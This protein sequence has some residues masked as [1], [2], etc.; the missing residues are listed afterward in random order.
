MHENLINYFKAEVRKRGED[1][2]RKELGHISTGS[3]TQIQ[4]YVRST[5]ALKVSLTATSI[6]SD[7]ITA[8]CSC[9]LGKKGSACK[10]MWTILLA[11]AES[12]PDFLDIKKNFNI[13]VAV[14][15]EDRTSPLKIK[16][17]EFKKQQYERQKAWAKKIKADKKH[18]LEPQLPVAVTSALQFFSQNGFSIEDSEALKVALKTLA[19][20]FHPDKGGT[21]EEAT[22]LNA[23]YATLSKHFGK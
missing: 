17:N 10:H 20:I 15:A 14:E 3:D 7:V 4:A 11:T 1:D 16:Q 22:I 19:R 13:S 8:T 18:R 21:H 23:H 6:A 9:R 2:F 5:P 12:F